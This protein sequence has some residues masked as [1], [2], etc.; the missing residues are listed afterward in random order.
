LTGAQL[1]IWAGQRLE[2]STPLYN[3]VMAF[4]I[5]GDIEVAPFL[6]AFAAMVDSTDALRTTFHEVNGVP[7]ARLG[8]TDEDRISYVDLSGDLDPGENCRAWI[9]ADTPKMFDLSKRLYRSALIKLG[10]S[11]FLWYFNQH[12]LIT[13]GW[14]STILFR[15]MAALY[16]DRIGDRGDVSRDYPSFESYVDYERKFRATSNHAAAVDYWEAK[17]RL[18]PPPVRLLGVTAPGATGTR[19]ERLTVDLGPDRTHQIALISD[20]QGRPAILAGAGNFHVLAALLFALIH[21]LSGQRELGIL[22]PIH[23]RPSKRL[24]ET[25]GLLME[26]FPLHVSVESHETFAS[27][28]AKVA[29]EVDQVLKH[30]VPGTGS[31]GLIR[32]CSVLLN[33]INVS[34][35][36]FAGMPT[37]TE[38]LHPGHGDASHVLRL[39]VHDLDG[40]GSYRLHFDV[41]PNLALGGEQ[42][43]VIRHFE[44]LLEAL[45]KDPEQRVADV[46]LLDESVRPLIIDEFNDTNVEYEH[47]TVVEAFRAQAR[48]T[49]DE[50][51][52]V[53]GE[54]ALTYA[55]LD[56]Q[57]DRLALHIGEVTG[58]KAP[59]VALS[60][61]RSIDLLVAIWG[62]LKA[63]GAYVP[64]DR[65]SPGERVAFLVKDSGAAM[66]LTDLTQTGSSDHGAISP[67]PLDPTA[68]DL[69]YVMYTSGSTGQP[70]GVMVSHGSLMNYVAWAK[71]QYTAGTPA[72]FPLYSSIAFDLTVTSLFVPLICGG[73]IVIYPETGAND[74]SILDV[75]TDDQ[76]DVVKLTP[77][78]LAVLDPDHL[79]TARISTL[80]VGGEDLTT[81]TARSALEASGGRLAI[82]NEYGP[83][84]AT[85]GCMIHRYDPAIDTGGSVGIGRPVANTQI[86]LLD[87]NAKPVPLGVV[88]EI[89]ISGRGVARGYLGRP[90]LTAERFVE[91]DLA[92]SNL[93]YRTGDLGRWREPGILE[94]LGRS[95]RQVKIRGHRV[96]LDEVSA[97]LATHPAILH[98]TVDVVETETE[99]LKLS[100]QGC[101]RCGLD[102]THPEAKLN[103]SGV[104]Q[105]CTFYDTHRADAERYWGTIDELREIFDRSPARTGGGTDC[106]MLLSGGKDST[107]ALY[108]LVEMGLGVV[109][110]TFDNGFISDGAKANI[111]RACST[112]GVELI[113]STTPAMSSIFAD[114]LER[115]SNVCQGC[116]KSIY[117]QGLNLAMQRKIPIVVTGLSRGQIF[118]TRLAD[119]FRIGVVDRDDVDRS[120]TD[121][122]RAYHLADDAVS[123]SLDT[124]I[125]Q[126]GNVFDQVQI[127]DFYR[128]CDVEMSEMLSFLE[129][130]APWVRPKDTGRSTN[131]LINNVGI[132]VHRKERGFH[133]YALPYSWDVR[134]GH[135]TRAGALA[136]LDDEIDVTQVRK[137]LDQVGYEVQTEPQAGASR[138]VSQRLAAYYV[139]NNPDLHAGEIRAFLA[140]RL[141]EFMIPSYFV[142]LDALPLTINGKVDRKT[143]P[144][145]RVRTRS[146]ATQYVAP[147][148]PIESKLADIWQVILGIDHVG[149]HDGFVELGGDSILNIQVVALGQQSGLYFSAQELFQHGSIAALAAV[150]RT[151]PDRAIDP[152]LE[153]GPFAGSGLTELEIE[154]LLQTYG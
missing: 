18:A 22:T 131:C 82:F 81:A 64:I 71:D 14:S 65:L 143:L 24:K 51:A 26:V 8:P 21:R 139:T 3:M 19:T 35:S 75:F 55:Q 91:S 118:E 105:W 34:V 123:R 70:K 154:E 20:R 13:D 140:D 117:T 47:S 93:V 31:A 133:N 90:D 147:R 83:T 4:R 30:G 116:F 115:F 11:D 16:Q 127:I 27:L 134:L 89:C 10:P 72:A 84:E 85:V 100:V 119:L 102:A 113:T 110:M 135:K 48:R 6:E 29:T 111:R 130:R 61:P 7:H 114:S 66:I 67:L 122:R 95:D 129:T 12:H 121:A 74:L 53:C 125:F 153:P 145:P 32:S 142:P 52:L 69:A 152:D 87:E 38:W 62:V 49:P 80:I 144:D 58:V 107:Y 106:L 25:A 23:N 54:T 138:V 128:Y 132:Y 9:E 60:L 96:E 112:L 43:A 94:F 42:A 151:E 103:E 109:A 136:E 88:G 120:I 59:K 150:V 86:Y 124:R 57:S 149:I 92:T 46:D 73:R 79:R 78:H 146:S 141:P 15:R 36:D 39:Q 28:I 98:T 77:S 44:K 56:K 1:L 108:Q 148:S 104:C 126:D 101:V 33:Y 45:I 17:A 40:A 2:P 5:A 76:V 68:E 50:I 97:A 137:I 63:G 99:R 37:S 41:S